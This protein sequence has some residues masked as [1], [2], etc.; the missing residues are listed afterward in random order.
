MIALVLVKKK[1]SGH[2]C[3]PFEV[4]K[5]LLV[6]IYYLPIIKYIMKTFPEYLLTYIIIAYIQ[7]INYLM[8]NHTAQMLSHI[9]ISLL[10]VYVKNSSSKCAQLTF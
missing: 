2:K 5:F 1:K 6:N 8:V 7:I 10:Y 9:K 4:L 3:M